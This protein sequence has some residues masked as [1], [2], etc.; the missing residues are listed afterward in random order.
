MK[1]NKKGGLVAYR[2]GSDHSIVSQLNKGGGEGGGGWWK[3]FHFTQKYFGR[4]PQKHQIYF[5][6]YSVII[7]KFSGASQ[8]SSVGFQLSKV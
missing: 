8:K 2:Y 4:L 1:L 7:R 5:V 6:G 3:I